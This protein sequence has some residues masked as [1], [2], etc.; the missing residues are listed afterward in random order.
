MLSDC[1]RVFGMWV[2]RRAQCAFFQL[3]LGL[4]F[5]V[6]AQQPSGNVLL[7]GLVSDRSGA[8]I[9][10]AHVHLEGAGTPRDTATDGSGKFSVGVEPGTYALTI[11]SGGFQPFERTGLIFKTGQDVSLTVV[12]DIPTHQ[13]ELTV[14]S[15]G[16]S[17]ATDP[18]NNL[19][20]FR[21]QNE[22]LAIFSDNDEIFQQQLAAIVGTDQINPAQ[23]YVDGFSGGRIPP[24]RALREVRINQNPLSAQFDHFGLDRIE[25]F[26]KPGLT[27]YHGDFSV[28]FNNQDLNAKNPFAAT[29]QPAY[30]TTIEDGSITGPLG[31]ATSFYVS[32]N[33]T[34]HQNQSIVNAIVLDSNNLPVPFSQAVPNPQGSNSYSLRVDRQLTPSDVFVA[35]YEYFSSDVRNGGLTALVLPSEATNFSLITQSIQAGDTHIISTKAVSE[36]RFQYTRNRSHRDPVDNS[37]AVIVQGYFKGG[38]NPSQAL[39]D[40]EDRYEFQ[41]YFSRTTGKHLLRVGGRYRFDREANLSGS[42]FNGQFTFPDITT[43]STTIAGLQQGLSGTAIRAMGGGASQFNVTLGNPNAALL[44]GDLGIYADDTWQIRKN[45]SLTAGLRF[46]SQ[47]AVPD[48]FDPAPRVGLA[49]AIQRKKEK[50]PLLTLR[51]GFGVFYDRLGMRDLLQSVRQNGVTEQAYFVSNPDFYPAVPTATTLQ[52]P[53][54]APV[55]A[56]QPSVIQVDPALRTSYDLVAT[57]SAEHSFGR[58]GSLSATYSALRGVHQYLTRNANAPLPGTFDPSV[59]NSGVR[60]FGGTQNIYEYDA[61]GRA[62]RNFVSANFS[63]Y[64]TRKILLSGYYAAQRFLTDSEGASAPVS[65]SYNVHADYGRS[66]LDLERHFVLASQ[67]SLPFGLNFLSLVNYHTGLP[68]NITTGDDPNGDTFYNDRPAFATDLSRASVRQTSIGA[69]D[70]APIA[71]QTI[72]PYNFGHS[73]S[74]ISWSPSLDA[75]IGV[76]PRAAPAKGT[77]GPGAR[78]YVL[79]LTLRAENVLNH[80]NRG[81]PIG[82]ISP[83]DVTIASCAATGGY[84]PLFGQSISLLGGSSSTAANRY[85][86]LRAF[87]TF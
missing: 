8:K 46:E 64:P 12:L 33:R 5:S 7:S 42:G 81:I 68:Y 86:S 38:G 21:F 56:N 45:L 6:P 71:G 54:F 70:T 37:V 75:S 1:R 4:T 15:D 40:N 78:P 58:F 27:A 48:H 18:D 17:S 39:H 52:N 28:D 2:Q 74:Y 47:F 72:V 41:Q 61:G 83:C 59:P 53:E 65:N 31:K 87:F 10:R 80:T 26:T 60:P 16:T 67:W 34:D 84:D 3:L 32:G 11:S 22:Q 44:S 62:N 24:K 23:L 79:G 9:V 19:S 20:A 57:I 69:F 63:I 35:R 66:G 25:V 29:A 14:R 50:S 51:P 85:V 30:H 43:Y 13:E 73:P 76:G 55:L 49:W 36:T 82:V 77:S